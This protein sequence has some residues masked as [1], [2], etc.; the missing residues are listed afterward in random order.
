MELYSGL[1]EMKKV[2]RVVN[3]GVIFTIICPGPNSR[4]NKHNPKSI[5]S[6]INHHG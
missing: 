6:S 2:T 1:W 4:I 5:Q 3:V